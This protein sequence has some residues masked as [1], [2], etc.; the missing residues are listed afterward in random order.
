LITGIL[1]FEY[2]QEPER[3]LR[4]RLRALKL[5]EA[6]NIKKEEPNTEAMGDEH[7]GDYCNA[8]IIKQEPEWS[9]PSNPNYFDGILWDELEGLE[10]ES[11]GD[12]LSEVSVAS[13]F[14]KDTA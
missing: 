3:T 7:K 10:C 11:Q 2:D 12:N 8:I 9:T 5:A 6:S 13:P 14:Y 4:R 1:D